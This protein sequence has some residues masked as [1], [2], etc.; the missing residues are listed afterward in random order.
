MINHFFI[1]NLR[2]DTI[3]ANQC[4]KL[5]ILCNNLQVDRGIILLN[6]AVELFRKDVFSSGHKSIPPFFVSHSGVI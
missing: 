6:H 1:L 2:G 5:K 4:N 3:I